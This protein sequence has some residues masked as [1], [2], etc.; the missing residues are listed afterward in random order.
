M[1]DVTAGPVAEVGPSRGTTLRVLMGAFVL[2]VA[3]G[4]CFLMA[5][6][7]LRLRLPTAFL[8]ASSARLLLIVP[9]ILLG[10]W[11]T[12]SRTRDFVTPV[13]PKEF[14]IG[15]LGP[16]ALFA[17]FVI[18]WLAGGF[19]VSPGYGHA[20]AVGE[21]WIL[22]GY[23]AA[24]LVE[25]LVF[26]VALGAL[27][28]RVLPWNVSIWCQALAFGLVHAG[29]PHVGFFALFN[30][31]LAGA[32]LGMVYAPRGSTERR[33]FAAWLWHAAWNWAQDRVLGIS[34]SGNRA[35]SGAMLESIPSDAWWSGGDYGLE[36]GLAVMMVLLVYVVVASRQRPSQGAAAATSL[37]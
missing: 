27:L 15:L 36:G 2:F 34:V 20:P 14:A 6:H 3:N 23:F 4:L 8:Q 33:L 1:S 11:A 16:A 10:A 13:R 19:V 25:E 7:W 30:T 12:R 9:L 31:V 35:G 29:N 18:A 21:R 24:A 5:P 37:S 26:R 28:M 22:S 17:A 32:A